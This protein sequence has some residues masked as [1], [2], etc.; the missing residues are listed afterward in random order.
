MLSPR[1]G[2]ILL[3]QWKK[4]NPPECTCMKTC[5][6]HNPMAEVERREKA[7]EA[8]RHSGPWTGSAYCVMCKHNVE[9]TGTI[10]T[11]DSGRQMAQGNCPSCGTKVNRILGKASQMP[12]GG[13]Q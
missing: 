2:M 10:R 4:L 3:K 1:V 11:S 8:S 5:E 7:I 9:F 12:S 6:V 13:A